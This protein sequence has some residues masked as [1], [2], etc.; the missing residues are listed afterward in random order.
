MTRAEFALYAGRR[1]AESLLIAAAAALATRALEERGLIAALPLLP[2]AALPR[3][4]AGAA[5]LAAGAGKAAPCLLAALAAHVVLGPKQRRPVFLRVPGALYVYAGVPVSPEA[6]C[7]GGL[8]TGSTGSGKTLACIMPRLHSLCVNQAGVEAPGWGRSA[9]RAALEERRAAHRALLREA[10]GLTG[11]GEP[12]AAED[13]LHESSRLLEEAAG[14]SRRRRYLEP[15]WGGLVCGEKGN[16]WQAVEALLSRHGRGEDACVLRTRPPGSG[17]LWRPPAR[18]N[19]LSMDAVPAD[20]YARMIVDTGLCVEA[21]GTR[22]EFFVPQARDKIAWGIRLLRA[23]GAAPSLSTL[24]DL[25]TVQESYQAFLQRACG[26]NPALEGSDALAEARYQL[27]HNYW[28]QPPDQLGGVRGTLYNFLIPYCEPEIA[29]V[30]CADSTFAIGDVE[31]GRVVCLAIPQRH[32]LQRR[33]VSA[34]LKAMTYQVILSRFDSGPRA[35]RRNVILV[36]QDEWQRHAVPADCEADV[37]R[38]ARGAVYAAAQSQNAV[39]SRLGGRESAAPLIANLRS[40][41]ICQAAAEECAAESSAHIG[42]ALERQLSHSSGESGRS[43]TVSQAER[44]FL[45]PR[46]LRALAP[47]HVV[48]VPAEGKWL[49]RHGIAMPV[50]ADGTLPPW[51][52]GDWNPLRWAARALNPARPGTRELVPPWRARAPAAALTRWLLGLDGTFI[53]KGGRRAG[54]TY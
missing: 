45:A 33:Y 37:V 54:K 25:L 34:L 32:A 2:A 22:D 18:L 53:V 48:F 17:P 44:A 12:G 38:E 23:A 19:L 40:R 46:E 11:S 51:W 30:F 42:S 8:A 47:F 49:Y 35:R 21:S 10:G 15:P 31:A 24:L 39:W 43:T 50:E 1:A 27:E 7:R 20:T 5:A 13:R 26:A 41:W 36:E 29:E 52:F 4:P 14:A 3:L 6:G 9:E 28:G 16:E